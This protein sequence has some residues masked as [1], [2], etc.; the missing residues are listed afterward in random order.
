MNS[1]VFKGFVA[2]VVLSLGAWANGVP[3]VAISNTV[4]Y[5]ET[6][7]AMDSGASII[8]TNNHTINTTVF[9]S[10]TNNNFI[11]SRNKVTHSEYVCAS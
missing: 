1:K 9:V 11:G 3:P 4:P 2:A 7:E 10:A 5:Q 6:F 8:V